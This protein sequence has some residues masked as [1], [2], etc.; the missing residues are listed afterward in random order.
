M[1][2]NKGDQR[3]K[4]FRNSAAHWWGRMSDNSKVEMVEVF[5]LGFE[6]VKN[7]FASSLS[8]E[9]VAQKCSD[10]RVITGQVV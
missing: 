8:R 9:R 4:Y 1:G 7:N 3:W 5:F 10:S 2:G 6:S